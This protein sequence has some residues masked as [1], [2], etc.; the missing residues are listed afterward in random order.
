MSA[1][2]HAMDITNLVIDLTLKAIE[3]SQVTF[4]PGVDR[5]AAMRL[6][7]INERE[8][9]K[10]AIRRALDETARPA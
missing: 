10:S 5:A 1:D 6:R 8:K 3:T 4:D 2:T 7:L 9:L